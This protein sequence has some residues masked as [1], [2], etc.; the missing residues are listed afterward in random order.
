MYNQLGTTNHV[1]NSNKQMQTTITQI[2]DFPHVM[3]GIYAGIP[4]LNSIFI[5]I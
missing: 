3:L 4:Y 1:L 2:H 5:S